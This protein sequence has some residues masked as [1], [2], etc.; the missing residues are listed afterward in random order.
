MRAVQ[1]QFPSGRELLE[2]YWGFLQNGGLVLREPRDLC[3]GDSLALDVKVRTLK[4]TYRL[5]AHVVRRD[6]DGA[7]AR[8]FVAFD[9][10][11]DQETMLNAA[12]ADTNEVPQ[13]KHKR[14]PGGEHV[15]FFADDPGHPTDGK[16][17]DFSA[18]GCSVRGELHVQ[19][20]DAVTVEANG[21]TVKGKVRW[22]KT[23]EF[24]VEFLRPTEALLPKRKTA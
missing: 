7:D 19:V 22:V 11:Q 3:E 12:W 21:V 17:M 2:S 1:V 9:N 24:G 8:T 4:Q 23:G 16:L 5:A 18:G 10:G 6:G 15:R 13:R 20:G 14:Y